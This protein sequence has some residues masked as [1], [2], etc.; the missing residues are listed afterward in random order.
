M[1]SL[2][3]GQREQLYQ[4]Y[5]GRCAYCGDP[6]GK[7]WNADHVEPVKRQ[8]KWVRVGYRSKW[9]MTGEMDFPERDCFENLMPSCHLCNINKDDL[10]LE[11]WRSWLERSAEVLARNYSTYRHAKRFGLVVEAPP[12]VVFFFERPRRRIINHQ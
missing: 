11:D 12:K 5:S 8:G 9:V 2:T 1:S 4:R 6:L 7:R 10:S 3:K